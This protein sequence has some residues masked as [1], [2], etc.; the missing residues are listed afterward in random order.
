MHTGQWIF[1]Y[2]YRSSIHQTY[3]HRINQ[4]YIA[5]PTL[6]SGAIM[7]S[8][9]VNRCGYAASFPPASSR[10]LAWS[11]MQ[12]YAWTEYP[13]FMTWRGID[14]SGQTEDESVIAQGHVTRQ[15]PLHIQSAIESSYWKAEFNFQIKTSTLTHSPY[16]SLSLILVD[17]LKLRRWRV[18]GISKVHMGFSTLNATSFMI[19]WSSSLAAYRKERPQPSRQH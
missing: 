11:P 12:K 13:S 16:L 18:F 14:S 5:M 19:S 8:N 2:T 17:Y 15:S 10:E 6:Q 9:T 7:R 1:F 4:L 3:H